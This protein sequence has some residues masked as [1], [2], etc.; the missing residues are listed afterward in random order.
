MPQHDS[1]LSGEPEVK[2]CKNG[3]PSDEVR[4]EAFYKAANF[5]V[6]LDD[7]QVTLTDIS[8]KMEE[9]LAET[10]LKPYS[11]VYLKKVLR[12]GN[13]AKHQTSKHYCTNAAGVG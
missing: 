7:V 8:I 13:N 11:S 9:F 2:K 12:A 6:G 4:K 10:D 5:F 1:K 3:R